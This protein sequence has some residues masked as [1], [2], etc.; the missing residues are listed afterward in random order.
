MISGQQQASKDR[1]GNELASFFNSKVPGLTLPAPFT[2]ELP[3]KPQTN[4]GTV[5]NMYLSTASTLLLALIPVALANLHSPVSRSVVNG[6]CTGAGGAP[7]VCVATASCTSAG[8]SYISNACPGTPGDIKC[9][10]KPTC[11]VGGN[12]RWTS[13]C[14]SGQTV[15]NQCPGPAD[16]KCCLPAGG[17]GGGNLGEKILAKAKQAK[18]TPCKSST[19]NFWDVVFFLCDCVILSWVNGLPPKSHWIP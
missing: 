15:A 17:G 13:Q 16:F 5:E 12:C 7:G 18:G 14:A 6:A 2:A 9:C 19:R 10:T 3:T 11:V 8:G 4:L 1:K